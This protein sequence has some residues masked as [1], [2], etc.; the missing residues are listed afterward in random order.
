[1][2]KLVLVLII[3]ILILL[4]ISCSS[5]STSVLEAEYKEILE[6]DVPRMFSN[7]G[8]LMKISDN[9]LIYL[10]SEGNYFYF[11]IINL[12]TK[13][14]SILK[15]SKG[16]GPNEMYM[17][18]SIALK[19]NRIYVY[20]MMLKKISI[21][22][23]EGQYLDD[24]YFKEHIGWPHSFDVYKKDFVFNGGLH[25][26]IVLLD[27][28]GKIYKKLAYEKIQRMPVP[29]EKFR[30]GI[31]K[32][33]GKKLFLGSFD[34]P[35]RIEV[36]DS[37]LKLE[38]KI[39]KK[40]KN[41]YENPVWNLQLQH[42]MPVGSYMISSLYMS[43]DYI[44]TNSISRFD[45]ITEDKKK[46]YKTFENDF[47]INVFDKKMGKIEYKIINSKIDE[48]EGFTIVKVDKNKIYLFVSED[49]LKKLDKN[50]KSKNGI[51][52]LNNP[53]KK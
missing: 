45:V 17:P 51:L 29:N 12:K 5:S 50:I 38:R 42:P 53:V 48:T 23:T 14:K 44:Y 30:G 18:M 16:K 6:L 21:Y 26:K 13:E 20:D 1:M 8:E 10:S 40:I 43:G 7:P 47:Y 3:L 37:D 9:K 25:N 46:K 11:N 36:Y 2:K 4:L 35:Y 27:R 49:I 41:N 31:I 33:D 22:D 28:E 34:K 15:I 24:I 19:D 52:I 32:S 39:T